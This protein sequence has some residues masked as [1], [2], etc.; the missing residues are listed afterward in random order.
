MSHVLNEGSARG[1]SLLCSVGW[2]LG[3]K[4]PS[5]EELR[6]LSSESGHEAHHSQLGVSSRLE[7]PAECSELRDTLCGQKEDMPVFK[8]TFF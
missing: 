2:F 5:T 3:Y 8:F 7:L 1:K 4:P 6:S